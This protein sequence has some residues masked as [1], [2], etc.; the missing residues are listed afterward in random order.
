M[1]E[2]VV[3]GKQICWQAERVKGYYIAGGWPQAGA[4]EMTG[5]EVEKEGGR[6]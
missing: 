2:D 4:K 1:G 5:E 6:K 3:P